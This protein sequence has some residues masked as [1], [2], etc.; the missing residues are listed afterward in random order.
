MLYGTGESGAAP[1]PVDWL[2]HNL[3]HSAFFSDHAGPN[4]ALI[5]LHAIRH[6]VRRNQCSSTDIWMKFWSE[7]AMSEMVNLKLMLFC[8]GVDRHPDYKALLC[9]LWWLDGAYECEWK[10]QKRPL[11]GRGSERTTAVIAL[12]ANKRAVLVSESYWIIIKRKGHLD[13]S[14]PMLAKTILHLRLLVLVVCPNDFIA[15]QSRLSP[16]PS[17]SVL[18]NCLFNMVWHAL[19]LLLFLSLFIFLFYSF[20]ARSHSGSYMPTLSYPSLPLSPPL[21]NANAVSH[22]KR[23]ILAKP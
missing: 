10:A 4:M 9:L 12:T 14:V 18:S 19:H 3:L 23:A 15:S 22:F 13:N 8:I 16:M 7:D 21:L 5:G 2:W 1:V 20:S 17:G 11:F 6:A